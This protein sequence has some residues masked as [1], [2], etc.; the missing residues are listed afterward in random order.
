[1]LGTVH[2]VEPSSV[3]VLCL[4]LASLLCYISTLYWIPSTVN[5]TQF[6][7]AL[8]AVRILLLVPYLVDRLDFHL[9]PSRHSSSKLTTTGFNKV[10]VAIS[11]LA[12]AQVI[13][14]DSNTSWGT[15][16][17]LPDVNYAAAALSNDMVMGFLGSIAFFYLIWRPKVTPQSH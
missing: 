3:L 7:P 2:V 4:R 11:L 12:F 15:S 5:T 13:L 14:L 10:L 16:A 1:M 6:F 9:R 8:F 17:A